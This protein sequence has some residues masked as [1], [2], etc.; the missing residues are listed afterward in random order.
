MPTFRAHP[1]PNPNSLKITAD[2]GSFVDDGMAVFRSPAEAETHPLGRHLFAVA[3]VA[4]VFAVPQ[5]VTVT[6]RPS[7]DWGEVLPAVE[8]ALAVYFAERI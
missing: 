6:K 1:T 4:D 2:A 5:F 8:D 7:A 3:G